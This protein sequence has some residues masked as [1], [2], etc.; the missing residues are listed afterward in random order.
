MISNKKNQIRSLKYSNLFKKRVTQ[1]I[2]NN[3]KNQRGWIS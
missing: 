3:T 1:T 2:E